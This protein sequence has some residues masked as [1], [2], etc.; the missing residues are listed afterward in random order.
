[1][2]GWPRKKTGQKTNANETTLT[3]ADFERET[4]NTVAPAEAAPVLV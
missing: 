2:S 4:A 1:M 3:Y